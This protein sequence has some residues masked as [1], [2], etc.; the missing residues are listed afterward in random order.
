[1]HFVFLLLPFRLW[2]IISGTFL[3]GTVPME[4]PLKAHISY[5]ETR[6]QQLNSEIMENWRTQIERNRLESEIRA[7]ELAL[8][9]Y[10]KALQ[11]E[12]QIH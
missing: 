6:L 8:T 1:M 9:Y 4:R 7:A 12:K 10:R 2:C 5:L 3:R 11:L